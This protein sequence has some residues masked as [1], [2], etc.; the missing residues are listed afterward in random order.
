MAER[1]ADNAELIVDEMKRKAR[2]RLVGA[3]VL[4]L[5]AA[6]IVPMLL[7]KEP[8]PL[9]DDVSVQIPPVDEGRFVNRLT[10]KAEDRK[11]LPKADAKSTAGVAASKSEPKAEVPAHAAGPRGCRGRAGAGPTAAAAS[12][13]LTPKKVGDG[14]RAARGGAVRED[15]PE[16]RSQDTAAPKNEA[17]PAPKA[18]AVLHRSRRTE[19]KPAPEGRSRGRGGAEGDAEARRR[20]PSRGRAGEPKASRASAPAAMP[21]RRP[22]RPRASSS[23]SPRS[24]TTR[25]P[26]RSRTS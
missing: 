23:N 3:I 6:I 15:R 20:S 19:A 4:A 18:E 9:G 1:I 2:R 10:G 24:P 14:R 21:P 26:T 25:A 17:K 13:P 5:A 7:E 16:G 22:R 12:E 11:P 8:R